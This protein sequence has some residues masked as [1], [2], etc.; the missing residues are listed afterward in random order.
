MRTLLVESV[1]EVDRDFIDLTFVD[2]VPSASHSASGGATDSVE[3][4]WLVPR[5]LN[6]RW[7][8]SEASERSAWAKFWDKGRWW[9]ALILVAAYLVL[10]NLASF[11]MLPF[12]SDAVDPKSANYVL[13][14]YVVPIFLG[15]VILVAFGATVGWLKG[16]F[17]PQPIKGRGWMWIAVA[18]VLVFNILRFATIDYGAAGLEYVMTWLLAGL[19]IGFAEEV[20][21]RGYVVRIMRSAGQP[22]IV[23]ALVS[24]ALFALMH[25]TNLLG[26]QAIVPTLLQLVYTFFFGILMYLALRVTGTLIAPILLHASTDPS[27]FLQSAFA[28]EGPLTPIAGLGNFAVMLAGLV[29]LFFIR[30]RVD[31]SI[32]PIQ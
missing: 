7:H 11:V 9:K 6:R 12:V 1:R 25:A 21:A 30:G 26:G 16:L 17:G 14:T 22:E 29:L 20:I 18:V 31:S 13:I 24:A 23:V 32:K 5:A 4:R 19:F 27:I 2:C 3:T 10:Y 15:G 8:V 28:A